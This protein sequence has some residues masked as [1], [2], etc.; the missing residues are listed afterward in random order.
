MAIGDW[1]LTTATGGAW[2]TAANWF[3]G[4]VPN[5]Q[6]A[7]AT[8]D[9][10]LG[11]VTAGTRTIDLGGV[12]RTVGFLNIGGDAARDWNLSNGTLVLKSNG[13]DAFVND[14]SSAASANGNRISAA[15]RLDSSATF[16]TD[17]GSLLKISGVVSET[18]PA[19]NLT[20]LGAGTL[21]LSGD[22]TYTG[23][24]TV[25]AGTLQ[26]GDGGSTGSLGFGAVSLAAGTTLALN[27]GSAEL[28][29][30]TNA[31]SG[32][33]TLEFNGI[34]SQRQITGANSGFSG[35]I[36]LNGGSL[37]A[38]ATG[39]LGT[40]AI[41]LGVGTAL[42]LAANGVNSAFANSI[43]GSG[44]GVT[45]S[46]LGGAVITLNGASGSNTFSGNTIINAG[47]TVLANVANIISANSDVTVNGTLDLGTNGSHQTL[48]NLSGSGDI[49]YVAFLTPTLTLHSTFNTE[50]SG[51]IGAGANTPNLVKTGAAKLTLSGNIED[52]YLQI[53]AGTVQIGNGG[54]TGAFVG[55]AGDISISGG[56]GLV[57]NRSDAFS[58]ANRMFGSGTLTMAGGNASVLTLS[59]NSQFY[60]GAVVVNSGT[61]KLG[62]ANAL[63][64]S[65][66]LTVDNNGG[67]GALDLNGFS[68]STTYT[69]ISGIGEIKNTGGFAQLNFDNAGNQT[70]SVSMSGFLAFSKTGAGILTVTGSNSHTSSTGILGGALA[71][72]G[73]GSIT[74]SLLVIDN[75]ADFSIA[76]IS[77]P[78]TSVLDLSTNTSGDVILG[79]KTLVVNAAGDFTGLR[80]TGTAGQ[81]D[82]LDITSRF[83]SFDLST[84]L[85]NTWTAGVDLI[86]IRGTNG[87][88]TLTGSAQNDTLMGSG[89][90]NGLGNDTLNGGDG[91]DILLGGSGN[92]ALFGGNGND[93]LNGGGFDNDTLNGGS[94]TD[95]VSYDNGSQGNLPGAV[96]DLRILVQQNT[97]PFGLDTL[98]SIENLTGSGFNDT[99]DGD[100][101][102]NT[103]NGIAGHDFIFGNGGA[104]TI[105]GGDGDDT[106]DGG[107][108]GDRL[109]GGAGSDTVSYASAS[110]ALYI[111]LRVVT[112]TF[113]G[114]LG[115]DVITTFENIRGGVFADVLIGNAGANI[116]HGG[117]GADALVTVEGDDFAYGESGDDYIAGRDGNDT[118]YGGLDR[119]VID[120]GN[121]LD[122][123]YGE[124]GDDYLIGGADSDFIYGGDGSGN[125]GDT[126]DRWLGGDG[127]DD[128]IF[129]NLGT[130]RL[131]G[132]IGNDVLTGGEGNDYMTGEAGMDVFVYNA[133]SEGAISEQIGDWQG[134]VDKLRIDA[135]AFG[136][137]LAAGPLSA[138]Q[139][140]MGITATQ[141]F[142]QF[143]YNAATGVLYW[144]A[145]GTGA[146]AR[147]AFT[148]LFTSAFTLPPATLAAGDFDIVA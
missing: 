41:V 30:L 126:G 129:G 51:D 53:N 36:N 63:G 25:S 132:G 68:P 114:G 23:T 138:N 24:T 75:S 61:I 137:G 113:T 66:V 85:F 101:F 115:T 92:D 91:A 123:L 147:V 143:L 14:F 6:G 27:W 119:D 103:L 102:V 5:A 15:V 13:G 128:F 130:D 55:I 148:R 84:A 74:S 12:T 77:G 80:F 76:G 121:G 38:S 7:F 104:D 34:N 109:D 69:S 43:T 79:G 37:S 67:I 127:G 83:N 18:G 52:G 26:V 3:A 96:V 140:V 89:D 47:A 62:H 4:S 95:T 122:Y 100:D 44:F 78:S 134:G 57:F 73:F 108:G 19:K 9:I 49:G 70:L 28:E 11:I 118:L 22:N 33:G 20:K 90:F 60:T 139:L 8:F 1:I 72:S 116:L 58:V 71:L 32:S 29:N 145:D 39:A 50:Y 31:L 42:H 35:T 107:L 110:G 59:G 21:V 97:N 93:L 82:T 45:F 88:D 133:L 112:Q 120:G 56:A 10:A 131:S 136:G 144:D 65:S 94:G 64:T 98:T 54:T 141:A 124:S 17:P 117:F 135:S 2:G 46:G 48:R 105:N 16:I 106:I 146:G 87:D 86:T 125:T 99:L 81:T 40:G 142:G 111:D